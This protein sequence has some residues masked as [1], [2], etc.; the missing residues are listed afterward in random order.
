MTCLTEVYCE[1]AVVT[2]LEKPKEGLSGAQ[3]HK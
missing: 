3:Y 1:S 2:R